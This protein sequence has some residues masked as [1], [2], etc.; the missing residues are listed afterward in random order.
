MED[1]AQRGRA[2][3]RAGGPVV[4]VG[5]ATGSYSEQQLREAGAEHVLPTL[6]QPLPGVS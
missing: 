6:E 3:P 2:D 5:V 1:Q 4:A